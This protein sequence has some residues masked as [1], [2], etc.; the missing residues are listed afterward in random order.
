MKNKSPAFQFYP[1]DYLSDIN[2]QVM[3]LSERGAYMNLLCHEWLEGGLPDDDDILSIL[4]GLGKE[5][6]G[7]SGEKIRKCFT[8]KSGKFINPRLEKERKNQKERK[9]KRS[10]AGKKGNETRWGKG[11]E[12]IAKGS[13]CDNNAIAKDRSTTT[14]SS[15]PATTKNIKTFL[16]DSEEIRLVDY[17]ISQIKINKSDFK[18]PNKQNWAKDFD[19]MIRRD[20][21]QAKEIAE[22]IKWCQNDSFEMTNVLCPDKLRKRFDQLA[23]KMKSKGGQR[24]TNLGSKP[25][26]K[27]KYAH[28]DK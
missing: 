20:K 1:K 22:L 24:G 10:D 15:T 8:I 11:S 13:Q 9:K 16:S 25:S 12:D 26:P 7:K 23:M 17:F 4:S 19:L 14:S 2:V 6:F 28:L 3:S 18:D 21:R 27:G 5:W